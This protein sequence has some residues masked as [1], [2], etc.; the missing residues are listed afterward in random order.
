M[1]F[2]NTTKKNPRKSMHVLTGKG[3]GLRTPHYR[4]FLNEPIPID[5]L[6]VHSETSTLIE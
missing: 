2:L 1:N 5:W 4:Q 6:E 3:I